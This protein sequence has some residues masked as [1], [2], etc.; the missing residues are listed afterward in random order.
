[1]PQARAL[2]LAALYRLAWLEPMLAPLPQE[3]VRRLAL[4]PVLLGLK[5]PRL[6]A[7]LRVRKRVQ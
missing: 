7:V 2:A 4:K 5:P 1:M 6:P 3:P